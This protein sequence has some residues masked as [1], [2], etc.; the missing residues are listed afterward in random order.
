METTLTYDIT[1]L[2][3]FRLETTVISLLEDVSACK[4]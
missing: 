2:R 1:V 4:Q 3:R